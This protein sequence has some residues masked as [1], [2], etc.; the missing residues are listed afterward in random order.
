MERII[1]TDEQMKQISETHSP[2]PV[3]DPKGNVLGSVDPD[4]RPEFIAELKRPAAPGPRYSSEQVRNHLR[5]LQEAW[6]RE[7]P[8]DKE[9][10]LDI[11]DAIRAAEKP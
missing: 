10:M 2:V 5:L 6:D 3:C 7:G 9:R 11:L 8:F 4:L 1:L